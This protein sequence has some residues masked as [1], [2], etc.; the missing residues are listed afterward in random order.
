[1][2]T[3]PSNRLATECHRAF[4]ERAAERGFLRAAVSSPTFP[5]SVF[6]VHGSDES[7]RPGGGYTVGE[8]GVSHG[9]HVWDTAGILR[10]VGLIPEL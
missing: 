6:F 8:G 4:V 7:P 2:T 10:N 9:F 1:M 3:K 5:P